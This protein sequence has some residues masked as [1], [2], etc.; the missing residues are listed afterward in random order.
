MRSN[1]MT[2]TVAI[3][4]DACPP[5]RGPVASGE[6]VVCRDTSPGA[7][8]RTVET[9]ASGIIRSIGPNHGPHAGV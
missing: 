8:L 4:G 1:R 2:R 9:D 6:W 5:V 3:Q 7:G